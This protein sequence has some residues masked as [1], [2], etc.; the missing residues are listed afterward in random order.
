MERSTPALP[1][2]LYRLLIG[3]L[4]FLHFASWNQEWALYSAPDGY[5]DH[6]VV[7]KIFWFAQLSLYQPWMGD[8]GRYLLFLSGWLA[9][10]L[11]VLG[12]RPRVSAGWAW[13]VATS[14]F[15]WNFPIGYLDDS[16][17]LLGLFW[18]TLLPSGNCLS[19]RGLR[20]DWRSASLAGGVPKV[21]VCNLA[22]A[23]WV[24]GLTKLKSAFWLKGVA[25]YCILQLNLA[26]THGMWALST[27]PW[28]KPLNYLAIVVES[29][30]PLVFFLPVGHWGRWLGLLLAVGLHLGIIFSIGVDFANLCWILAWLIVLREDFGRLWGWVGELAQT[31]WSKSTRYAV[32]VVSCIALSMSEGVPGLKEAYGLGFA[33]Q[34]S[35]GMSQEYHLFDWVEKFNFVVY[36]QTRVNGQLRETSPLPVGI[37]GFLFQSYLLDMRWMRLPRGQQ[38][39]WQRSLRQRWARQLARQVGDGDILVEAEV[40]RPG[41]D[42]LDLKRRWK[43]EMLRFQARKGQV[44]TAL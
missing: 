2:D 15:R 21:L 42:N 27:L 35:L 39:E 6:A 41:P 29:S 44:V 23:Y 3:I 12:L 9:C 8:S 37:R 31:A 22:L 1:I 19:W 5:L 26:R 33:L 28:L 36:N 38:G 18:C 17:I 34:W 14:H 4:A 25:L 40:T 13:A 24:T 7:A 16:S 20:P 10:L 11:M 32:V 43:I 30:L